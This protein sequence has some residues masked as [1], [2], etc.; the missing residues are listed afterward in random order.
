MNSFFDKI[1]TNPI[2]ASINSLE[3]LDIALTSPC[4]IIFLMTGNIFNLKEI[5]SKVALANK[6]L[7]IYIDLIDGFSKDTWGLEYIIKNI[8]LDGIITSKENLVK[9]SKDMGVFTIFRMFIPDSKALKQGLDFIK[10]NHP[11][12]IE[13]LPAPM[14]KVIQKISNEIQIPII[15]SGLV[16]DLVDV[17]NILD[18]GALAISTSNENLWYLNFT[19][20][21]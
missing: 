11:H 10:T 17:N 6:S 7:Y 2:I 3:K 13:I 4:E 20:K 9:L 14:T 8:Q 12:G 1:S 5:S 18:A 21:E 15:A 16:M 19:T